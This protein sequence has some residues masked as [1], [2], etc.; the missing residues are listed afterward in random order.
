MK[1]ISIKLFAGIVIAAILPITGCVTNN[2]NN[3]KEAWLN[4]HGGEVMNYAY[5]KAEIEAEIEAKWQE[6]GYKEKPAKYI[7]LSFDDGPCS[8]SNSGGTAAMLAK[9]D[10]LK[11]KTT[12]FVIGQNVRSNKAAAQAIFNSGH[13]LGNHSDGYSSI[14]ESSTSSIAASLDAA[15]SAIKEITGKYPCLFRAP[16]LNHGSNLSKVCEERG[17]ALIDGSAHNDWDGTGHTP[18]SIKNSVLSNPQNGGIVILHDNNTSKGDTMSALPDIVNG[19]RERG[20][21]ILTIGQLAAVKE[22]TLE[23]GERYN[24]IY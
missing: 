17:M 8:T 19:L 22:K 24:S 18:T 7:A 16:N 11:V 10:E 15:S 1:N 23:A 21:W 13:E 5:T 3:D 6:Y 2:G 14:G 12:F 4:E 20:F 9:L